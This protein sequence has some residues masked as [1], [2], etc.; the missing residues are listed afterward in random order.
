MSLLQQTADIRYYSLKELISKVTK[1][2]YNESLEAHYVTLLWTRT[3]ESPCVCFFPVSFIS[4]H[5]IVI[6]SY[7][8][9]QFLTVSEPV[10]GCLSPGERLVSSSSPTQTGSSRT[11][12]GR[13]T[14]AVGGVSGCCCVC[15]GSI[16][17]VC[18]GVVC[19]GVA[20]SVWVLL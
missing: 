13:D 6:D 14:T 1:L 17:C 20:V 5:W 16:V 9:F 12:R 19:L 15:L 3:V 2:D 8:L 7:H 4:F 10:V 11:L 18:L